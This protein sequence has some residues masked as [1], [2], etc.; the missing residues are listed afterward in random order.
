MAHPL[1]FGQI[2][3]FVRYGQFLTITSNRQYEEIASYDYRLFYCNGGEGTIL[4]NGTPYAMK[5]GSVALWAPGLE[6]S[7]HLANGS[8]HVDLIG[9]NFDYTQNRADLAE[10]IPP[11]KWRN[12]DANQ[13]VEKIE[14][15]DHAALNSPIYANGLQVLRSPLYHSASEYIAKKPFYQSRTSGLLKS[16]LAL[17]AR[18]AVYTNSVTKSELLADK[19]I[20]HINRHYRDDITNQSLGELFGYHPNH[21]NRIVVQQTGMSVHHYLINCRINAAIEL[22]QASDIKAAEIAEAVGFKDISHFL[23]YFKKATGKTTRDF[24]KQQE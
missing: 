21:L 18:T 2:D 1:Q 13:I 19:V 11:A 17:I 15:Q 5:I 22:L 24:R 12:F 9:V 14:F 3:P 20:Q 6:Y 16:N 10:P 23:K 7:L 8:D 4:V